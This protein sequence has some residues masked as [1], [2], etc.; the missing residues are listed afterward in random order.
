MTK[1][2]SVASIARTILTRPPGLVHVVLPMVAAAVVTLALGSARH[3]GLPAARGL[4]FTLVPAA[5]LVTLHVRTSGFL[6]DDGV[7][8]TLPLPVPPATRFAL[9]R[10]RHLRGL[11]LQTLWLTIAIGVAA[12]AFTDAV[13]PTLA[14]VADAWVVCLAAVGTEPM[15]AAIAAHLG[16]RQG[17][18]SLGAQ[19][20][21]S[22]G[23]GWTLPEAV[24]HLYAPAFSLALA[25]A[26]AMPAQLAIDRVA[27]GL[28]LPR[29]L[30][31]A[32]GLAALVVLVLR[33][34]A[35]RVYAR[36]VFDAV[37]WLREA[38]RTLAGPPTPEPAP[39][40]IGA[41]SDPVLRL[42]LLQHLRLTPVPRLRLWALLGCAGVLALRGRPLG[43]A[44][45]GLLV[46][47]AALWLLP[48]AAVLRERDARARL[49]APL[50]VRPAGARALA[51][52]LAPVVISLVAVAL[53]T[54]GG[55]IR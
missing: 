18:G 35:P 16:R 22:L 52:L 2:P 34:A 40:W 37:P 29:G 15:G 10:A 13:A 31:V 26:L 9:A 5:L 32:C 28:A 19:L 41:V 33:T 54:A 50:P 4:A 53:R 45:L 14:L 24:V 44:E 43:A 36:G 8:A 38:M 25:A 42:L 46:A 12:R 20:Q 17:D 39:R 55:A 6:H 7:A 1:G 47:T 51:L 48:A 27:D 11:A 21:R 30:L 23:G 3:L 49:L